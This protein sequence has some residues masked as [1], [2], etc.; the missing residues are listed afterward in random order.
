MDGRARECVSFMR[1]SRHWHCKSQ[2]G[3]A[4]TRPYIAEML[5]R[6]IGTSTPLDSSHSVKRE[7]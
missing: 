7:N 1:L 3:N 6:V 2:T 5:A 4:L